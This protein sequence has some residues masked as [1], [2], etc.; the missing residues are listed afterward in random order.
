MSINRRSWSMVLVFASKAVL[1]HSTSAS[2]CGSTLELVC[3]VLMC[4]RKQTANCSSR[5]CRRE[6]STIDRYIKSISLGPPDV[7]LQHCV[8]IQL[9]VDNPPGSKLDVGLISHPFPT[10]PF[11]KFHHD[12]APSSSLPR[13][14]S[15]PLPVHGALAPRH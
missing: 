13:C 6:P 7:K 8:M 4:D 11:I 15:T 5:R 1:C 10:S 3:T 9:T 14:H 2:V 12:L